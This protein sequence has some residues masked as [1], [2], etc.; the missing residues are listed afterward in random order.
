VQDELEAVRSALEW[1][2]PEL[3]RSTAPSSFSAGRAPCSTPTPPA[4]RCS[5]ETARGTRAALRLELGPSAPGRFTLARVV[6]Q[7]APVEHLAVEARPR[8]AEAAARAEALAEL[9]ARFWTAEL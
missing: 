4:A 5:S 9:V 7:G 2:L 8:T 3:M 1:F 6:A